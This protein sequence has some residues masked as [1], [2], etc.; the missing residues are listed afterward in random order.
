MKLK[1]TKLHSVPKNVHL[2]ILGI[3]LSQ[4]DQFQWFLVYYILIKFDMHILEICPR[5]VSD[6]ATLP[7]E[8][9]KV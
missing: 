3:I 9:Q 2:F 4:I 5:N 6:V 1:N 8:I 7:W